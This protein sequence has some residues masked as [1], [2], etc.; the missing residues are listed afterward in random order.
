MFGII[1]T[2]VISGIGIVQ[3][4][5]RTH[6]R[7]IEGKEI[8]IAPKDNAYARYILGGFIFGLGWALAGVCPAPM[9]ILMG[10][11]YT[12]LVIFLAAAMFGTFFYGVIRKYLPHNLK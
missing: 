1:G 11:G 3:L 5:R 4:I 10:S 7:S 6:M 8:V 9:F 12:V 2:A